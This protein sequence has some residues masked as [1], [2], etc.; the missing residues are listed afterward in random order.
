V[1]H[2]PGE[3]RIAFEALH[4]EVDHFVKRPRQQGDFV[5]APT[6]GQA[7]GKVTARDLASGGGGLL[8]WRYGATCRPS[9]PDGT[10]DRRD[11]RT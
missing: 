7:R 3:T 5:I 2:V 10:D 11:G 9:S 4:Q 8:E 1:T 6:E